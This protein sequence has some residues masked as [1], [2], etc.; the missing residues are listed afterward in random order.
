MLVERTAL[1]EHAGTGVP[2][3]E[4]HVLWVEFDHVMRKLEQLQGQIELADALRDG[5]VDFFV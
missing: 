1:L 3:I 2:G 5:C 4:Q